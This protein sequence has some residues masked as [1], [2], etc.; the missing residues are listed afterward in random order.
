[1][2]GDD[3]RVAR[4]S[5][6]AVGVEE[7]SC[8]PELGQIKAA[9]EAL[10]SDDRV[11]TIFIDAD[12]GDAG[13][14]LTE[15]ELNKLVYLSRQA[16][17]P[18]PKGLANIPWSA[19]WCCGTPSWVAYLPYHP[20]TVRLA[21][22]DLPRLSGVPWEELAPRD[23]ASLSRCARAIVDRRVGLALG[24]G[25]VW[26]FAHVALLQHLARVDM[27][28]DVI[29]GVSF[30]SLAAAFYVTGGVPLLDR[31]L[32]NSLVFQGMLMASSLA[33]PLLEL[34][35]NSHLNQA[36][37][38]FLE[39]P[40]YPVALN[41]QTGEEWSPSRG[42]VAYGVRASELAGGRTV[43]GDRKRGAFGGRRVPERRTRRGA[44]PGGDR[45]RDR[46]GRVAGTPAGPRLP[47]VEAE[48]VLQHRQPAG[49]G[50]GQPARAGVRH[51]GLGR[52][53]P[54][55]RPRAVPAHPDPGGDVGLHQG[56]PGTGLGAGAGGGIRQQCAP[57][58]DQRRLGPDCIPA[59]IAGTGS[60]VL[61]PPVG[62]REL[63]QRAFP[64]ADEARIQDLERKTGI[65]TRH[66][67]P[68]G[69]SAAELGERALRAA[70]AAAGL[71]AEQLARIIFVSSTGG[72]HLVPATGHDIAG[73]LQLDGSCDV[74]DL[75]NGCV[76]FLSAV[77]VAARSIATGLGP[78][79]IVAVE[80]F[81]RQLSPEG[82]RAYA[83]LGD[84]AAAAVLTPAT[85]GGLL[86][87]CLRS[88]ARLRGKMTMSL[89][90]TPGARPFH[91][92]DA[93]SRELTDS[94]VAAFRHTT[95]GGAAA[96]G[97][98]H[99]RRP[100]GGVPPAQRAA[101]PAAAAGAGGARGAHGVRGAAAGQRRLGVGAQ[102]PRPAAAHARRAPGP[103]VAAGVGGGGNGDGRPA[104]RAVL[105]SVSS[106]VART[107]WM[108]YWRAMS[109]YHRFEVRGLEHILTLG[110]AI[111][112]GYHGRP[113]A[114]DLCML[115]ARLL[116]DHGVQTRAIVHD[117]M[118]KVPLLGGAFEGLEFVSR[119]PEAIARAVAAGPQ[120]GGVPGRAGGGLRRLP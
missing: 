84:A 80:I 54:Q 40:F 46:L 64:E 71:Q 112:A 66:W 119:A 62:T 32:H 8:G 75:S 101:A 110:P 77:D 13:G 89:P 27:P 26:G 115:Q 83:V 68:P 7:R 5:A 99:G 73:R 70:L 74:F 11:K 31:L 44:G 91:D 2:A 12:H 67:V 109:R 72:D 113:G 105:M 30:G 98:D 17:E 120:A 42:T 114:R 90:G 92:F 118:L 3:S 108:G 106:F 14:P 104:V 41:L 23:R 34:Y 48:P 107:G 38:E 20:R 55:L 69:T 45:L 37:L 51:Q 60:A 58:L 36:R 10:D 88:S 78:V 82:P 43:A 21:F 4:A 56:P 94:A 103:A 39:T 117:V 9:I 63:V 100:L 81:S 52:A 28:I 93:R 15:L 24:G 57:S 111:I 97:A 95:G 116:Y 102:R 79:A 85:S 6:A 76:G 61:G 50:A 16:F 47:G 1:M 59:R 87:S 22:D 29:S 25:G 65:A 33:P 35:L 53:R 96:G 19:V 86:A 49:T 18:L